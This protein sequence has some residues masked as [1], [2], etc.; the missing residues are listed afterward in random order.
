MGRE[1][2]EKAGISGGRFIH[3]GILPPT[4]EVK[5]QKELGVDMPYHFGGPVAYKVNAIS[6]VILGNCYI[7]SILFYIAGNSTPVTT[8][9]EGSQF[10]M[11]FKYLATNTKGSVTDVWSLCVVYWEGPDPATSELAGY[12]FNNTFDDVSAVLHP[13][14]LGGTK[15][16]NDFTM[17]GRPVTFNFNLFINDDHAPSVAY[18]DKSVWAA[19]KA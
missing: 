10:H 7:Q 13:T 4:R 17:P 18:P 11:D 12:Y 1:E 5:L 9:P 2:E 19:L 3:P 8:I 16:T 15:S 6:A 14:Y